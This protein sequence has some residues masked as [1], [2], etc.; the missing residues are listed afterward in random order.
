M[1]M[2]NQAR[3]NTKEIKEMNIKT[4]SLDITRTLTNEM[5]KI[6]EE[7][8]DGDS[9]NEDESEDDTSSEDD[10]F[11]AN[12][13]VKRKEKE[14]NDKQG[15][16]QKG[17]D[18]KGGDFKGGFNT[19]PNQ[20][21]DDNMINLLKAC[22]HLEPLSEEA[23]KLRQVRLGEDNRKLK[24]LILD[25][26]ETLIH[27]KFFTETQEQ[28]ENGHLGFVPAEN[29]GECKQFNIVLGQSHV[30]DKHFVRLNV[31]VRQHMEEVL[32][33]LAESW[34]IVVFTAGE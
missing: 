11:G 17:I 9:S 31:K 30:S 5:P 33:Y 25:M 13:E 23:I 19:D 2:I 28:L 4:N 32:A 24:T 10:M 21:V 7:D 27:A 3:S 1:D 8:S 15:D 22:A 26:D 14:M 12:D 34:E 6:E 29:E 20:L 18:K 16:N